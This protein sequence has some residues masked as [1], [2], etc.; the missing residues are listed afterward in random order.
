[1]G[2]REGSYNRKGKSSPFFS[3]KKII[4]PRSVEPRF[5]QGFKSPISPLGA[6]PRQKM[7]V[8]MFTTLMALKFLN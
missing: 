2:G 6:I 1:M 4:H 7:S 5:S 3:T 8:G